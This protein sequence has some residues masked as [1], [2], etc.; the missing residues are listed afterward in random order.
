MFFDMESR[1]IEFIVSRYK[2]PRLILKVPFDFI[3]GDDS[4]KQ[5]KY[6]E[7]SG[8]ITNILKTL[9]YREYLEKILNWIKI[10]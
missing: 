7:V 5:K 1:W 6:K 2:Y 8:E 9:P 4:I 3:G 10:Q